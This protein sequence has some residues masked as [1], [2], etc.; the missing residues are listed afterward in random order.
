MDVI[1]LLQ[2]TNIVKNKGSVNESESEG[3]NDIRTNIQK[4]IK[5]LERE[6]GRDDGEVTSAQP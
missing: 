5:M 3:F 4:F 6:M 2:S 1:M